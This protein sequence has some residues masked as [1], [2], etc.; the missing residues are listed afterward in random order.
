MADPF[1][2]DPDTY[3]E[4]QSGYRTDRAQATSDAVKAQLASGAGVGGAFYDPMGNVTMPPEKGFAPSLMYEQAMDAIAKA[5][6]TVGSPIIGALRT[7]ADVYSNKSHEAAAENEELRRQAMR[8]MAG[9]RAGMVPVGAGQMLLSQLGTAT[10]PLT[11]A[12][13]T[14][15]HAATQAT[16]NPRFGGNVELLS[17]FVDPSHVGMLKATAP[18]V[19]AAAARQAVQVA[20]EVT[21]VAQVPRELSPLGF[22][23]YGADTAANLAQVKGAPDQMTAMLRKYGVKPDELYNAGIADETATNAMRSKIER[24]YAPKLAAAK[25]E[26][27]ALGLNENTINK[28]SPDYNKALEIRQSPE[29]KAKYQYDSALNAMRSDMDSAMVLHPEWS[30][31]PS[32][33]REELAKH[34]NERRPQIEERVIAGDDPDSAFSRYG[35]TT[36]TLPG[37]ENYREVLLKLPERGTTTG[38]VAQKMFGRNMN[39]LSVEEGRA[40]AEEMRRLGPST[41]LIFTSSHYRDPNVIAH[42]RFSDR[43]GPNGEKILHVEEI[44]SDWG[45]KGRKEGFKNPQSEARQAEIEDALNQLRQEKIDSGM[46]LER[47]FKEDTQEFNAE[48]KRMMKPA[49]DALL[50]SKGSTSDIKAYNAASDKV[51]EQ[52]GH[53]L[54]PHEK[55]RDVAQFAI[56]KEF[57]EKM[58]PLQKE[59]SA[60]PKVGS[61]ET[62]PYVTNTAAWTDLAL[63]RALKEATE[64]GYDRLVW[65]PGAEQ[66]KRYSLTNTVS[67][68]GYEPATGELYALDWSGAGII[69][70]FA[71][72]TFKPEELPGVIGKDVTEKL[73]ST[74]PN[75]NGLHVLNDQEIPIGGEGMKG[76]YD[77]IFPTQLSKLVK[78]LDPEARIGRDMI[79]VNKEG[80]HLTDPEQTVSGKW[81]VKSSDYNLKGMQF[82]TEAAARA[83]LAEKLAENGVGASSLT[84]TPKMREAIMKGQTDF[85]RG[86]SVKGYAD[87]GPA[88]NS[89][90]PQFRRN[91]MAEPFYGDPATYGPDTRQYR[92]GRAQAT[93]DAVNA[94]LAKSNAARAA[95]PPMERD[96]LGTQMGQALPPGYYRDDANQLRN[97]RHEVV[98][99]ERMPSIIPFD[100]YGGITNSKLLELLQ[101]YVPGLSGIGGAAAKGAGAAAKG[102]GAGKPPPSPF[103]RNA[104]RPEE[105]L[106]SGARVRST[107]RP[108]A[109]VAPVRDEFENISE[110][111]LQR[112]AAERIAARK[113]PTPDVN[114][115][116]FDDF[117][118]FEGEGGATADAIMAARRMSQEKSAAE[119][120][121]RARQLA[122]MGDEGLTPRNYY[123]EKQAAAAERRVAEKAAYQARIEAMINEGGGGAISRTPPP[124]TAFTMSGGSSS[125]APAS[126]AGAPASASGAPASASGALTSGAGGFDVDALLRRLG[127]GGVGGGAV[128]A[129]LKLAQENTGG[130][131]LNTPV[132]VPNAAPNAAVPPAIVPNPAG[133]SLE[134]DSVTGV[135]GGPYIGSDI[136]APLAPVRPN[137]RQPAAGG[138]TVG[139]SA[140]GSTAPASPAAGAERSVMERLFGGPEYQS[141]SRL[142][143]NRPQGTENDK[144]PMTELNWG[145]N[146]RAADFVRADRA[147]QALQK[148]GEEFAGMNNTDYEGRA[149]GGG[150]NRS[151]SKTSGGRDAAIHKALE[152][153]HHMMVNR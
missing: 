120:A 62:A 107:V 112:I 29:T 127:Y 105:M 82:D 126:V 133:P 124:G 68:I 87:G 139:S 145:D 16:G 13:K 81:M 88:N 1:Y 119:E 53:L 66:A 61:T 153:I 122:T 100:K 111:A 12:A 8:N 118:R 109:P 103:L 71:R 144:S 48:Y 46:A 150:V 115:S 57:S 132:T 96:L 89:L 22:Y 63:K 148:G 30:S 77:K 147:M 59:F 19:G 15:G 49:E 83:A 24:E 149:S 93:S 92:T 75:T 116:M 135:H 143:V 76:Y 37:G 70:P 101:F 74:K 36:I 91:V 7:A 104:M 10:L 95:A 67:R 6:A 99:Q 90:T 51:T 151:S 131:S 60:L 40:V 3:G 14:I 79:P 108:L 18:M 20:R 27:D 142:V 55:S 11:A 141:N 72:R 5:G 121:F 106:D 73:L 65:T 33:T 9:D 32:V 114:T 47:K 94:D 43:T 17:G 117:G 56:Q 102:A 86:G 80:W 134:S 140:A 21:P 136:P 28:K 113:P 45:Q 23:S 69:P 58:A 64:G 31:R 130:A 50:S 2:S 152:I 39:E 26:M 78:K 129:A 137:A 41:Q 84:I 4:P 146:D 52:I 85:A 97:K 125:G 35:G 54:A 138:N 44:Q 110:I 123:A 42:L 38:G 25:L 128:L 98:K 34:F